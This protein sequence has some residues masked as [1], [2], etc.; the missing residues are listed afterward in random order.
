M[1]KKNV[2]WECKFKIFK[3]MNFGANT[4]FIYSF[5]KI[6]ILLIIIYHIKD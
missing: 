4:G 6:F 3:M 5:D 2:H 1:D